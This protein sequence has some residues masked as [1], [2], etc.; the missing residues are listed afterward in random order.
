METYS[1]ALP[2]TPARMLFSLEYT[3]VN[4]S[5]CSSSCNSLYSSSPSV[6]FR[7][8]IISLHVRI[9]ANTAGLSSVC[10]HTILSAHRVTAA[11]YVNSSLRASSASSFSVPMLYTSGS[12][13]EISCLVIVLISCS[14]MPCFMNVPRES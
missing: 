1:L 8:A 7:V 12:S 6:P 5:P 4:T 10:S 13:A 2:Y 9:C 3:W 14:Y 11:K